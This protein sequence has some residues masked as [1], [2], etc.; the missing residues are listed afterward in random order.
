MGV[1]DVNWSAVGSVPGVVAG[2]PGQLLAEARHEVVDCPAN[3]SIV[4][5][6]HVDVQQA[7]GVPHS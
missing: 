3:D 2:G 1:D 7:D 4:V 5:H 6:P